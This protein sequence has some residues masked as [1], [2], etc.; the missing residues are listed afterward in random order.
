[1]TTLYSK[2]RAAYRHTLKQIDTCVTEVATTVIDNGGMGLAYSTLNNNNVSGWIIL[3]MNSFA[4]LG[5]SFQRL[6]ARYHMRYLNLPICGI[7]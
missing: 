1:M 5:S 4:D 3:R 2:V 7:L 6:R